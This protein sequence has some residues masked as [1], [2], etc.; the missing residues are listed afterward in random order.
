MRERPP[1]WRRYA[2]L[3][4]DN[5]R[6]D[7]DDEFTFHLGERVDALIARGLSPE[8]ARAE[9]IA[10]FGD[11]ATARETCA[12]IGERRFFRARL[13]W[14][15]DSWRQDVRYALRV[16]ARTPVFAATVVLTATLGIGANAVVF[17]AVDALLLRPL[18]VERPDEIV[19]IYTSDASARNGGTLFGGNS[20]PDYLEFRRSP[21]LQQVAAYSALGCTIRVGEMITRAEGRLVSAN[22]FTTLGVRAARGRLL[23]NADDRAAGPAAIV[24]SHGFW[25]RALGSDSSVVGRVVELNGAVVQVV[26]V[27]SARFTGIELG[28]VDVYIPTAAQALVNRQGDFSNDRGARLLRVIGRAAPGATDERIARDLNAIMRGLSRDYPSTNRDRVVSV[29][30]ATSLVDTKTAGAPIL[31]VSVLLFGAT[32][33]ILV[34]AAVNIASLILARTMSRSREIAVRISL[35]AS[36]RRVMRQ[37]FTESLLLALAAE[38]LSLAAVSAMRLLGHRIGV[39]DSISVAVTRRVFVF[40]SAITLAVSIAFALWPAW[41]GTSISVF[42][43][44]RDHASTGWRSRARVQRGLVVVQVSL[45]IVLLACAALLLQSFHRQQQIDPGFDPS[46]VVAAEFETVNGFPTPA[47]E[48][49]FAQ[50][51]LERVRAL[52]T[53]VLAAVATNPPLTGE[54]ARMSIAIPGYRPASD[55]RMEIPFAVVG[56]DYFATLGMRLIRGDELHGPGDTLSRIVINEAMSR[57]YWPGKD[58]VGATLQLGD[59][60]GRPIQIIGIAAD[61]RLQ[62]LAQAPAPRFFIQSRG[63]GGG[64]LLVRSATPAETLMPVLQ[65]MF[66]QPVAGFALRR[67]R[68]LEQVVDA[69]LVTAKAFALVIAFA[70]A[71]AL[72]LAMGGL[73]GVVNYIAA[74]RTKEFGIR[75]AL[76][77]APGDLVRMVLSSGVRLAAAGAII[78]LSLSFFAGMALRRFLFGVGSGDLPTLVAVSLL[79]ALVAV[80]ACLFPAVHAARTSPVEPLRAD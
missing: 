14:A 1:I 40:A 54:G 19:R 78:G 71:V 41:R 28:A 72:L 79:T 20:Y 18:P 34:I 29:A 16:F 17:S 56:S 42:D 62:S 9:A 52:P 22:Y 2:R 25:T 37:L 57:R 3:H 8:V 61:A 76:G 27:A 45:S 59:A 11:L 21:A 66:A 38:V 65:R 75:L 46:H 39:P 32:G 12:T 15:L 44:L 4:R 26:G 13:A 7:V 73:Y 74:Q 33:L 64:S 60:R 49:E 67:V 63:G 31:P 6:R 68:T 53:V 69:S 47:Q 36:R 10:R 77:A 58:P 43:A 80:G 70:A 24:L 30:R 35:G 55:E 48:R 51:T 5:P 23:S 50:P